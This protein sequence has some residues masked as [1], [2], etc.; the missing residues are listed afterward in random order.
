MP[1]K[2]KNRN[3][4]SMDLLGIEPRTFSNFNIGRCERDAI[5]LD[6]KPV[7][8]VFDGKSFCLRSY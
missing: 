7:L 4:F 8:A 6:H 2:S 3:F 1:K 5:P